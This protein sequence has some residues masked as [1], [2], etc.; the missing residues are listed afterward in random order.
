MKL[1]AFVLAISVLIAVPALAAPADFSN[2]KFAQ[3]NPD[4]EKG[5][6]GGEQRG[7]ENQGQ[8]RGPQGNNRNES[9]PQNRAQENNRS[10]AEA[11]R[12]GPR[13]GGP[14]VTQPAQ[15]QRVQQNRGAESRQTA[16]AR[17]NVRQPVEHGPSKYE[18]RA[19]QRN[20]TASRRFRIGAFRP[21]QGWQYRRWTFGETLPRPFWAQ[22]YW[23][24]NFWLYDLDRPPVGCEWVR[25]GPD[26]LLV[27]TSSGEILEAEYNVFY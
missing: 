21:P 8:N 7:N 27:D 24:T 3:R 5:R 19:F 2:Q 1:P 20:V 13:A 6:G 17:G 14:A 4:E 25:S 15:N 9:P 18:K 12:G 23:I 16:R 10:Q 26:A 22:P 11:P